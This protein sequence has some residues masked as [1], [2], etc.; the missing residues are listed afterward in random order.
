MSPAPPAGCSPAG[1]PWATIRPGGW[2]SVPE[3]GLGKL[4]IFLGMAIVAFGVLML[5]L[6]SAP[7]GL[8]RLP[9]DIVWRRG[10]FTFFF[11]LA[12]S[13]LLSLVLTLVFNLLLRR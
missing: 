12:S 4:L 13:L 3:T 5:L 1:R 7:F 8:G 2:W 6:E 11:P 10:N 9:G